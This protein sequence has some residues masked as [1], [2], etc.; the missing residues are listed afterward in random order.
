MTE[1]ISGHNGH[2]EE[3]AISMRGLMKSY[4]AKLVLRGINLDA[5]GGQIIGYL[6]PNGAGKTTTVKILTGML[7][8]FR[9]EARVCGYDVATQS[10]E[11]KRRIGYVPETAALYDV[12]TPMEFLQFVGRIHGMS[13]PDIERRATDLLRLL[14][15]GAELHGRMS[16]FSKGMRQKVLIVAGLIHDPQVLFV[17]EPL[18][19][20]DANAAMIVKEIFAGLARRGKTIFFCSHV[21]DVVERVCDRI[22]ILSDGQIVADGTFAQLQAMNK[23]ASLERIFSQL[24]SEGGHDAIAEQFIQTLHAPAGTR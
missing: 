24:T 3:P 14:G 10:L 8:D 17:D 12:L 18:S 21:M 22:V 16:G 20:L 4:D 15:L 9:G 11:V 23:G 1:P 19:G 6:G 7:S 13:D 2:G 5:P